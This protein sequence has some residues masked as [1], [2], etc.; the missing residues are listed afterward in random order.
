MDIY[1]VKTNSWSEGPRL[2]EPCHAVS[3]A[4][5]EGKIHV[6]RLHK[7]W[8]LEKGKW[9]ELSRIPMFHL[10]AHLEAANENLYSIASTEKEKSSLHVYD[11]ASDKWTPLAAPRGVIFRGASAAFG[12]SLFNF[13]HGGRVYVYDIEKDAWQ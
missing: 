12:S 5:L 10:F 11:A 6:L 3:A 1:D 9:K 8:V 2:P 13:G 7:H 4:V